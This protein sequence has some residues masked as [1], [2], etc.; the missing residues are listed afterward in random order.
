M[1]CGYK[2]YK[3]LMAH[4]GKVV[5][6]FLSLETDQQ[7]VIADITRRMG[8]GMAEFIEKEVCCLVH[9]FDGEKC[10]GK[11]RQQQFHGT[12]YPPAH[13]WDLP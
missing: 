6:V 2:H 10:E 9:C 7:H 5:N 12:I 13:L 3:R 8:Y 11:Y 1:A 4:F